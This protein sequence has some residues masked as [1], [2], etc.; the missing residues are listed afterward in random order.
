M[1]GASRATTSSRATAR[2][3]ARAGRSARVPA[4]APPTA[5]ASASSRGSCATVTRTISTCPG[6]QPPSSI[7]YDDDEPGSPWSF[8]VYVDERG[9]EEQ[10]DGARRILTGT[11]GGEHVLRLPWVRK[12]SDLIDVRP[13]RSTSGTARATSCGSA[14]RSSWPRRGRSRPTSA[15]AAASPA[16]TSPAP[17]TTPT[18]SRSPTTPSSGSSPATAPTS[19]R[20]PTRVKGRDAEQHGLPELRLRRPL[21]LARLRPGDAGDAQPRRVRGAGRRPEN[22]RAARRTRDAGDLLRPRAT[23]SSRS[24]TRPSRSSPPATSSP[25]TPTRTSTRAASPPRRSAAI[26]SARGAS[27]TGSACM[28]FG[29]RS[30]SADLSPGDA[31]AE[32]RRWGSSTTR[33]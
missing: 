16:T 32:S 26:W 20:S 18:G 24:R 33:A 22:P 15:S 4:A 29:F 1:A 28:P 31:R 3:S 10:R 5:S 19:A 9:T 13:A 12:P 25:T 6:S 14:R 2:R 30:P 21:G 11:L 8:V 7:R 17:S 27:S 23:P